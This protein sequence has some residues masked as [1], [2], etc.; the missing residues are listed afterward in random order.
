MGLI[1]GL[2]TTI[3]HVLQEKS[4]FQYPEVERPVRERYKGRHAL[5]R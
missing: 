3:K 2:M 1:N 5:K 4:T